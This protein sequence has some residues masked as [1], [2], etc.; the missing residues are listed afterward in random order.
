MSVVVIELSVRCLNAGPEDRLH[1]GLK[2]TERHKKRYTFVILF[3]LILC[4]Y[5]FFLQNRVPQGQTNVWY[6][7]E[8]TQNLHKTVTPFFICGIK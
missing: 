1:T 4:F 6:Q 8:E 7:E 5:F 3:H 2:N